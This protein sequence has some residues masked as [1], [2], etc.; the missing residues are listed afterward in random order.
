MFREMVLLEPQKENPIPFS[1]AMLPEIVLLEPHKENPTSF[2][3]AMLPDIVLLE[4]PIW[5][6]DKPFPEAVLSERVDGL[7]L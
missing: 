7:E 2:S 4:P 1:V 5:N 3:D 6:P